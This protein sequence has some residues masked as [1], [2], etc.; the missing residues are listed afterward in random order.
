MSYKDYISACCSEPV[1][2]QKFE[3]GTHP[4]CTKCGKGCNALPRERLVKPEGFDHPEPH[5][6]S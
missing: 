4:L 3:G 2:A 1:K 5:F 6:E